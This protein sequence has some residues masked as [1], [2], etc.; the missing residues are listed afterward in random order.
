MNDDKNINYFEEGNKF[1]SE[2]KIE[3]AIN[4]F[5]SFIFV[6]PDNDQGY[7]YLKK[8]LNTLIKLL[9]KIKLII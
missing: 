8:Q 1:Y 6:E 2:N 9:K 3:E 5:E 7:F 4:C